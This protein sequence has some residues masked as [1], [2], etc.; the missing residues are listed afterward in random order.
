MGQIG[1]GGGR[2]IDYF[3]QTPQTYD[4]QQGQIRIA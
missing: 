3:L 4:P 2:K 1:G